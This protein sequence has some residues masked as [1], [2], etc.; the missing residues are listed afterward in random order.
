MT[1]I[2]MTLSESY[3]KKQIMC[4]IKNVPMFVSTML[5]S[6]SY[7]IHGNK[8]MGGGEGMHSMHWWQESLHWDFPQAFGIA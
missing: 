4:F 3:T 8:D 6:T 1:T 5:L 2:P 7:H